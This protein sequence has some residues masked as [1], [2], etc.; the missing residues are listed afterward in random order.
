MVVKQ[1]RC[2]VCILQYSYAQYSVYPFPI[3][4]HCLSIVL[5]SNAALT[6]YNRGRVHSNLADH[7]FA[8]IRSYTVQVRNPPHIQW[9][10]PTSV[11][12]LRED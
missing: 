1:T 11:H 5:C 9:Y 4:T 6:L 7:T 3:I 2:V 8:Y 12:T 10:P